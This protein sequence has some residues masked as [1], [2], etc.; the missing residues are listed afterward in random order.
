MVA[1]NS[2]LMA[3]LVVVVT[4]LI[5]KYRRRSNVKNNIAVK[6]SA[7]SGRVSLEIDV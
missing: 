2:T 5:L 7:L 4:F 3:F 1:L 6:H